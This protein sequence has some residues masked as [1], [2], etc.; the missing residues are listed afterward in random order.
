M[1]RHGINDFVAVKTSGGGN[2][3]SLNISKEEGLFLPT[4]RTVF[5]LLGSI[6]NCTFRS[7]SFS[8]PK[9][10]CKLLQNVD[11]LSYYKINNV[12]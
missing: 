4:S 1:Y 11:C 12:H 10:G 8:I 7:D 6:G 3:I 9:I 2:I 5:R